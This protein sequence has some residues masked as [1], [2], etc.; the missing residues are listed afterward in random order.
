MPVMETTPRVVASPYRE[1]AAS[2]SPNVS[3]ASATASPR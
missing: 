2:N 1:A 3:P